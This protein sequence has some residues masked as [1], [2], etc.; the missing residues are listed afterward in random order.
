MIVLELKDILDKIISNRKYNGGPGSGIKGHRT[1]R[2]K[3]KKQSITTQE[4]IKEKQSKVKID[5]EKDNYFPELNIEDLE[6]MGL[7]KN[8]PVLLKK[9]TI[10]RN[11]DVHSEIGEDEYNNLI[12]EGIYNNDAIFPANKEKPYFNFLA[13]LNDDKS[14][15]VLL[16]VEET[17]DNFEIVHIHYAKDKQRRTLESKGKRIRSDG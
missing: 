15:V 1:F 3:N 10:D 2:D 5:F 4:E 11:K 12:R 13:R 6:E 9:R 16:D 8:K 17:K 14:S 7:K